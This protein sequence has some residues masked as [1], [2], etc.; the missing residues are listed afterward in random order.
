MMI[1]KPLGLDF[2]KLRHALVLAKVGSYVKASEA[3]HITQSAL[4]HSIQ[5]LEREYGVR[6]F[7]RGRAG[8][9]PT[10]SGR[11]VLERAESIVAAAHTLERD[12]KQINSH[13]WGRVAFGLGPL[14]ARVV[15]PRLLPS[16]VQDHP[17]IQV[18]AEI[19]GAPYLVEHLQDER[20]EFFVCA[21]A[22]IEAH[23]G[24]HIEPVAQIPLA[25]LVRASH[26]LAGRQTLRADDVQAFPVVTG[27]RLSQGTPR[28]M[29]A[30]NLNWPLRFA[31]SCDDFEAL[32]QVTLTSDVCWLTTPV[33]VQADLRAG[34]LVALG[35]EGMAY[36]NW[37]VLVTLAGRTLSAAAQLVTGKIHQL[38][39]A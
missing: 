20:I 26:P 5:A 29:D 38:L 8:V 32:R 9:F 27:S 28:G 15:L 3:L 25:V 7:D 1:E 16:L 33:M 6:L 12:L 36:D 23:P 10:A 4:T 30:A 19:N 34:N 39:Q 2:R 17:G 21:A 14:P 24:L 22:Q 11:L 35:V 18:D 31:M 37:Q 13:G